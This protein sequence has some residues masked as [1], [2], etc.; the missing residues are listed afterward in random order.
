MYTL[1]LLLINHKN[2]LYDIYTSQKSNEKLIVVQS[3]LTR[4]IKVR[5]IFYKF[6]NIKKTDRTFDEMSYKILIEK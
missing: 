1:H 5:F 2:K 3:V 4:T 6:Q